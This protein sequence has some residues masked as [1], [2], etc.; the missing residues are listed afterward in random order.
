MDAMS[1]P[2]NLKLSFRELLERL[3]QDFPAVDFMSS[4]NF[5]W[6]DA[7][8]TI[9]Y[10]P[11]S[12]NPAWSLLHEVGHMLNKHS[13]YSSDT[14]LVRM[15]MEAWESAKELAQHYGRRINEDYIQD[16][17]DSYRR[18]QHKRSSCPI[19]TQTGIETKSRTYRCINCQHTW[20]VNAN[21]LCR[22]YRL[23]RVGN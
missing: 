3:V 1:S 17:M 19:C 6:S 10:N 14:S 21:R 4:N 16:C 11:M 15:E 23:S 2:S 8:Q 13:N 5:R 12:K 18:W 7:D 20:Q 22:V 9:Y